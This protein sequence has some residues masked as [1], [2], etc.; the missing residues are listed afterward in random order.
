MVKRPQTNTHFTANSIYAVPL[1]SFVMVGFCLSTLS[2]N[3]NWNILFSAIQLDV[4]MG[5]FG[6]RGRKP[7]CSVVISGNLLRGQSHTS[8]LLLL[9]F[10]SSSVPQLGHGLAPRSPGRAV[11][12]A[13]L[14][15]LD[16]PPTVLL[17]GLWHCPTVMA[18]WWESAVQ[19]DSLYT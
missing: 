10:V 14:S 6:P 11:N 5:G 7:Q 2:Q 4:V 15:P 16:Q 8:S 13:S 1:S 17:S 3:Q 12:W 18:I 9:L 19:C